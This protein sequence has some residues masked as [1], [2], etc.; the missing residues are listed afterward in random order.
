MKRYQVIGLKEVM[1]GFKEYELPC[2]DYHKSFYGKAHVIELAN[3]TK[4]LESY[5]TIVCKIE[6]EKFY[7]LWS[8]YSATTQ[9][10]INSFSKMFIGNSYSKSEWERMEVS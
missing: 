6:N 2:M 9:R 3:G 8:G 10:H 5:E 4:Y 7:R 1:E